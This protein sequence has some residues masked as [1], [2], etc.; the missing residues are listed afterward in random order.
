MGNLWAKLGLSSVG[1]VDLFQLLDAKEPW[2]ASF[3]YLL[4]CPIQGAICLQKKIQTSVLTTLRI[5]S[6]LL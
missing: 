3:V 2:R 4:G 1:K 5:I 6:G